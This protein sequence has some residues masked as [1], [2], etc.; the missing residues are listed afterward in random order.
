MGNSGSPFRPSCSSNVMFQPSFYPGHSSNLLLLGSPQLPWLLF[1]ISLIA[2]DFSS[3]LLHA[4]FA[5]L[6]LHIGIECGA[7]AGFGNGCFILII[8][9]SLKD[10]HIP[11]TNSDEQNS[12]ILIHL[13]IYQHLSS[14]PKW[15]EAALLFSTSSPSSFLCLFF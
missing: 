5:S 13:F 4:L 15:L 1:Q 10:S 8:V 14:S 6:H 3:F 2:L 9:L 7:R 12:S 11:E